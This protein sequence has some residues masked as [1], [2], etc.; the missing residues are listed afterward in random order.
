MNAV[1]FISV[2][3]KHGADS[4]VASNRNEHA[5]ELHEVPAL[6]VVELC[7]LKPLAGAPKQDRCGE[8][9]DHHRTTR[10]YLIQIVVLPRTPII[11]CILTEKRV[12]ISGERHRYKDCDQRVIDILHAFFFRP[13]FV[14][15][16][17][18]SVHVVRLLIHDHGKYAEPLVNLDVDGQVLQHHGHS[19]Q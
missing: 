14:F 7:V 18:D 2:S 1:F 5:R 13:K 15:D 11:F 10:D 12:C 9:I 4:D 19:E 3:E 8:Q 6:V 16:N 17:L